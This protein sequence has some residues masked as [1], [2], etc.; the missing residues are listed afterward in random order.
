MKDSKKKLNPG[1]GTPNRIEMKK[2]SI[3]TTSKKVTSQTSSAREAQK[4]KESGLP[5]RHPLADR[6]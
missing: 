6:K 4:R 5:V 3:K 2:V 1:T